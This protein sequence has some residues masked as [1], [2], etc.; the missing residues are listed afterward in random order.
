MQMAQGSPEGAAAPARASD[1][2]ARVGSAGQPPVR[3]GRQSASAPLISVSGLRKQYEAQKGES[4]LALDRIDFDVAD[5]EFVTLVGPSGCGKSTLLQILAGILPPTQGQIVLKGSPVTGPRRDVGVV[6]QEPVLLP[7][8]KVIDNVLLPAVVHKLDRDKYRARAI[9]LLTLVKL[10]GFE[11]RYPF[12]LSGGMQQRVAIARALLNDP[13]MILMDEPFGALDAMTRE[14]MNLELM[15]IWA[16]AKK[17]I[18]LI[19]HSIQEAV[20]LSDR[21]V[22]LSAR[23][24]R[25]ID[26]VDIDLPRPRTFQMLSAPEFGA[27]ANRLRGQLMARGGSI[28]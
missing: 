10:E 1:P 22:V 2:N 7:W 6:F 24:G 14:Q 19:T 27:A 3:G 28:E 13:A 16:R 11:N 5:G 8:L 26:V 17:T 25:V 15:A 4:V 9:E 21:V 18:V 20:F 23:P 12:E